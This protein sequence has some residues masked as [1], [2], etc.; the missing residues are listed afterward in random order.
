M[1]AAITAHAQDASSAPASVPAG[2]SATSQTTT[3]A[4]S[5]KRALE[6]DNAYIE[7]ARQVERQD[8]T[9][10]ERSF[11]RAV[12]LNPA[13]P[14]YLMA[15]ADVR[16]RHLT[17]LVQQAAQARA[18]GDIAQSEALLSQARLIDPDNPIIAQHTPGASANEAMTPPQDLASTLAGP[19]ELKVKPGLHSFHQ[20]GSVRDAITAVYNAFGI[21]SVVFDDSV[22]STSLRFD[23]EDADFDTATKAIFELAH[24]FAVPVQPTSV[25]LVKDTQEN[26]QKFLPLL[27]EMVYIPG[28]SNDQMTELANVARNIFDLKSVTA[29]P[30][31]GDILLR[32]DEHT[33]KVVNAT[34]ANLVDGGSEVQFEMRLYEVQST[35]INDTGLKFPTSIGAFSVA[36]EASTLIQQNQ[37]IL[38]QAIASGLLVLKGNILQQE[39]QEV[40]FLVGAGAVNISQ[41]SNFLGFVGGGLGLTGVYLGSNASLNLMLNSTDVRVLDE[42]TLRS[43]SGK[44]INFRAGTRYPVITGTYSSGLSSSALAGLSPSLQA[45]ASKYLGSTTTAS[46]PQFQFEDLGI[47]IK[48]TPQV[49]GVDSVT[50][51]LTLK[52]EALAGASINDVPVLQS[53]ALDSD[54][55]IPIGETAMLFSLVS[56]SEMKAISGVPGLS[57]LPGFVGTDKNTEKDSDELLVTITP[58]LV[59]R[60]NLHIAAHPVLTGPVRSAQ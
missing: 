47:T 54:F 9:A 43:S 45:L 42:I 14:E 3:P 8:L 55:T 26:R 50:L 39:I 46:V 13:K 56:T 30:S 33:L 12:E 51:K 58:H 5:E 19:M 57:A 17:A 15:L 37:S 60:P 34:L 18:R 16:E 2:V 23:L 29:S 20:R 21:G 31:S 10:A 11:T 53:R 32:G 22:P 28:A 59:R 38:Q 48:A 25:L 6:A 27:E 44:D 35:H 36:S 40:L 24:V 7:G 41:F 1:L 52:I 49:H 4:V